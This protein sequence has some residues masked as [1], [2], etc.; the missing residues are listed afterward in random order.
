[1]FKGDQIPFSSPSD[2]LI[3]MLHELS[4]KR[5]GCLVVVDERR[6]LLGVFTDGDLRRS[7]RAEGPR[8]LEKTLG[9]L[10]T[11]VPKSIGSD[12]LAIDAVRAME[13][14]PLRPVTVMPVLEG[15][16]VVGLIRLHDILQLDVQLISR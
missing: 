8:A 7:I 9:E 2:K 12:R 10:M 14:D 15:E 16:C 1:M 6:A 5:C 3:D 11:K 4:I 13:E